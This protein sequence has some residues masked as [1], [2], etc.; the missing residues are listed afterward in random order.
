MKRKRNCFYTAHLKLLD[1]NP[2]FSHLIILI[3]FIDFVNRLSPIFCIFPRYYKLISNIN[4][5]DTI[6]LAAAKRPDDNTEMQSVI[7]NSN[8]NIE[9]KKNRLYTKKED[10]YAP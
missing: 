6:F 4:S 8:F 7:S 2:H 1:S 9:S 5:T 10:P 3:R